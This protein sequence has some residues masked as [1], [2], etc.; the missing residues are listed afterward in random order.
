MLAITVCCAA[1]RGSTAAGS[2]VLPAVTIT[3]RLSVTAT[4]AFVLPEVIEPS[5]A[6]TGAGQQPTGSREESGA[7]GGQAGDGM[8]ELNSTN[9]GRALI[10]RVSI[11][12]AHCTAPIIKPSI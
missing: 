9:I 5:Q 7:R 12:V 11:S 2:A 6:S 4:L 8:R 1:A 3:V 10:G